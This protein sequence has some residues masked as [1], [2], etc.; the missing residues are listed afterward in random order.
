M[1]S[2]GLFPLVVLLALAPWAGEGSPSREL[3]FP[4]LIT[5]AGSEMG[6][7]GGVGVKAG[8]CPPKVPAPC[9][10]KE[11]RECISDWTCPGSKRCCPHF[12]GMRCLNPHKISISVK[13]KPGTCPAVYGYCMMLNPSNSCES[14][15]QC[16]AKFKCCVG[17]CGKICSSPVEV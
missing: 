3:E 10:K 9:L 8:V 15:G 2:S 1:K 13:E 11:E 4:G 16:Q 6:S 17:M 7:L 14:D 12:C 5:A